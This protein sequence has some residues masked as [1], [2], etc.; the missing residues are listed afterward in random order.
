MR[1]FELLLSL[2]Y[3]DIQLRSN[4]FFVQ[5]MKLKIEYEAVFYLEKRG[6]L[7]RLIEII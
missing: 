6:I 1:A 4:D 2:Q 7:D 5:L 3:I